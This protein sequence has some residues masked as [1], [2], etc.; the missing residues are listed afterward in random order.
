MPSGA[1]PGFGFGYGGLQIPIIDRSFTFDSPAADG[2]SRSLLFTGAFSSDTE[3]SGNFYFLEPRFLIVGGSDPD[4]QFCDADYT[5]TATWQS[6][7]GPEDS[8]CGAP[9]GGDKPYM[10]ITPKNT[11]SK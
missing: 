9:S 11:I 3:A 1:R 10:V 8:S 7:A 2:D 4:C 6:A 5:W